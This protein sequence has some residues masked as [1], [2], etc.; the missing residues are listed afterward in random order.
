MTY[1]RVDLVLVAVLGIVTSGC[2]R[3]LPPPPQIAGVS[4]EQL[5]NR[6]TAQCQ[7]RQQV[8]GA[9]KLDYLA[10][11]GVF[12]GEADIAAARPGLLRV[13]LRSFFGQAAMAIAVSNERFVY[14]DN[15]AARAITGPAQAP[16]LQRLLPLPLPIKDT[17]ALLMGCLPPMSLG[18]TRY[19]SPP[20]SAAVAIEHTSTN[21]RWIIG[22]H[23]DALHVSELAMFRASTQVLKVRFDDFLPPAQ[24]SFARNGSLQTQASQGAIKW[25]WS[26]FELNGPALDPQTWQLVIPPS[27]SVETVAVE[28]LRQENAR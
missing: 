14:L 24:E 7:H 10:V 19:T 8:I 23:S 20:E 5:L 16:A 6:V 27:F 28:T 2:P 3:T 11:D 15:G 22:M 21:E 26:T 13:E 1:T 25:S 17:V 12:K 18:S 4:A 9:V